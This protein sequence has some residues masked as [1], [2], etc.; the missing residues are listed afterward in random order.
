MLEYQIQ[1]K[2]V[3]LVTDNPSVMV[4]TRRLVVTTPGFQHIMEFR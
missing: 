4:A 3:M 2:V 1:E